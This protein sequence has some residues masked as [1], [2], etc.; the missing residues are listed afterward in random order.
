M[1]VALALA[2]PRCGSA[3]QGL[4]SEPGPTETPALSRTPGAD[5]PA[6]PTGTPAATPLG[7]MN[8]GER[9]PAASTL[10]LGAAL[11]LDETVGATGQ[12]QGSLEIRNGSKTRL[13]VTVQR[14]LG[15]AEAMAVDRSR[16]ILTTIGGGPKKG[17]GPLPLAPG[18]S[19]VFPA[20]G[21]TLRCDR[22]TLEGGL[23]DSGTYQFGVVLYVATKENSLE[24]T[25]VLSEIAEGRVTADG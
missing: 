5:S 20:R 13:Y 17:H 1:V 8:C 12:P 23:L 3:E 14:P 7:G 2:G 25:P 18:E 11:R 6:P 9:F 21:F 15:F 16:A 19:E 22:T 4:L 10:G 24:A